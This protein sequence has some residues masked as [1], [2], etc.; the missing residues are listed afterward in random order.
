MSRNKTQL[1]NGEQLVTIVRRENIPPEKPK[2]E[3]KP[4]FPVFWCVVI[5][6]GIVLALNILFG[7][8]NYRYQLNQDLNQDTCTLY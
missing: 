7:S 4:S 3:N 1:E 8:C 5:S 6:V 2:Q